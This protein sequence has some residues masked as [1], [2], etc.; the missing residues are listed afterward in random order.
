[1]KKNTAEKGS[2]EPGSSSW[3]IDTLSHWRMRLPFRYL[4]LNLRKRVSKKKRGNRLKHKKEKIASIS[5]K[6]GRE[7]SG[8]IIEH[9]QEQAVRKEEI[10]TWQ[11]IGRFDTTLARTLH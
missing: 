3:R 1:M 10:Q 5:S 2:R 6:S 4:S 7:S 8:Q 11:P 9:T